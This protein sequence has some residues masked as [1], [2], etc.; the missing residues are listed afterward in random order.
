MLREMGGS[1]AVPEPGDEID[2]VAVLQELSLPDMFGDMDGDEED[3]QDEDGD[4]FQS[5]RQL[6]D[7]PEAKMEKF[8]TPKAKPQAKSSVGPGEDDKESPLLHSGPILGDLP[9][10]TGSGNKKSLHAEMSQVVSDAMDDDSFGLSNINREL[11]L[12][13]NRLKKKKKRGTKKS[14]ITIDGIPS[15]FLCE[16]CRKPMSDPVETE[17]GNFF[18]KNIIADWIAQQGQVCPVTGEPLS[19]ADLK[20]AEDLR[21]KITKWLLQKSMENDISKLEDRSYKSSSPTGSNQNE[22]SPKLKE[23]SAI[24]ELYEF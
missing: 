16:L 6:E 5:L 8:Q 14:E 12:K 17:Y 23:Q 13:K 15:E 22:K 11:L 4:E 18:E 2:M 9:S 10:L 20:P 24:D 3:F 1:A 19:L 21:M 7:K